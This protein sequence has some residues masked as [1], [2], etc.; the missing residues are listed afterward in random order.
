MYVDDLIKELEAWKSPNYEVTANDNDIKRVSLAE[1][2][3]RIN[4]L[5]NSES[6]NSEIRYLKNELDN[7]QS[8]Y[9][10]LES[11][12]LDYKDWIEDLKDVI[13]RSMVYIKRYK[14][15][16]DGMELN[17]DV[18]ASFLERCEYVLDEEHY[19]Y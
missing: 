2:G 4:L 3:H 1:H 10:N 7:S 8:A 11:E 14:G 16:Y 18:L 5:Y 17:T 6:E 15:I 19:G 9:A 13:E 12:L